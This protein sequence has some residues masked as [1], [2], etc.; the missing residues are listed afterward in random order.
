MKFSLLMLVGLVLC[1]KAQS[2]GSLEIY[3]QQIA[4]NKIYIEYLEKGYQIARSGLTAIGEIKQGHFQLDKTFFDGLERVN[5][6]ISRYAKVGAT[7]ATLAQ[8][9]KEAKNGLARVRSATLFSTGE[10]G[11]FEKVFGALIENTSG[12]FDEVNLVLSD[13]CLKL[14]DDERISQIDR[15]YEEARK[16]LAYVQSFNAQLKVYIAQRKHSVDELSLLKSF[17]LRQR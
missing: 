8:A 11:Y 13:A 9:I 14:S 16:E 17:Y 5:P 4:A 12:L 2:Q 15:A 3:I 1:G 7:M 6:A 10:L